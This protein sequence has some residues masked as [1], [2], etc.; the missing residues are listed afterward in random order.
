MPESL[1]QFARRMCDLGCKTFKR[2]GHV[3]GPVLIYRD[4][5]GKEQAIA[6]AVPGGDK[7]AAMTV[8][9]ALLEIEGATRCALVMETWLLDTRDMGLTPE[10]SA[11]LAKEANERGV[12]NMAARTE[13][14]LALA[15]DDAEGTIDVSA[16]IE[17]AGEKATLGE[18]TVF[19]PAHS[20][21]RMI[22][23]LPQP[24]RKGPLQ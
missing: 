15:E 17:R 20:E 9:R 12:R 18:M 21:G 11:A 16:R 14:V 19:R 10:Q 7:D 4:R 1:E 24:Q 8:C 22:G 6:V 5:D 2:L 3:P 23:L 13:A